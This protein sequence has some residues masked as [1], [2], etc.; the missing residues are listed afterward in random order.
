[1]NKGR[2]LKLADFIGKLK[3]KK[4]DMDTI[5]NP[6]Y[7]EKDDKQSMNP[8]KCTSAACAMGWTPAVFP[9]LVEWSSYDKHSKS[10]EGVRLKVKGPRKYFD[11]DAMAKL[12]SI[13]DTEATSLFGSGDPSYETPKQVA[14]GIKKFVTTNGEYLPGEGLQ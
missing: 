3:P 7:A 2:L 10:I 5:V 9:R 1:M 8:Y 13:T 12:F 14:K 11:W 6:H 4:L